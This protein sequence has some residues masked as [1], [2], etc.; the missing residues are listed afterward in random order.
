M[1][2]PERKQASDYPPE[3]LTLFD[4]YVH[5]ALSLPSTAPCAPAILGT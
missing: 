1:A 3:V 4:G 2:P 5:G